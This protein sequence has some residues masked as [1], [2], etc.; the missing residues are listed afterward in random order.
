[1]KLTKCLIL[2]IKNY[3]TVVIKYVFNCKI[4]HLSRE[5]RGMSSVGYV[6]R[7]NLQIG[8]IYI[9]DLFFN[10]SFI[11]VFVIFANSGHIIIIYIENIIT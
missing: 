7:Q 9:T 5:E 3:N 1:M 2:T 10:F 11:N 4:R 6:D 8:F